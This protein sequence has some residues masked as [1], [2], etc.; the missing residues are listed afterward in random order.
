[1]CPSVSTDEQMPS[2]LDDPRWIVVTA[3][4]M[5][6][7]YPL[8]SVG[9]V[10]GSVSSLL[11]F[12][13]GL[14]AA[15]WALLGRQPARAKWARLGLGPSRLS[16]SRRAASIVG[17]G[18][19]IGGLAAIDPEGLGQT[20]DRGRI[21]LGHGQASLLFMSLVV[22]PAFFEEVFFRGALQN[23]LT[24]RFGAVIAIGLA[25]L[26][27]ASLHLESGVWAAAFAFVLGLCLASLTHYSGS[28]REA[29]LI[30]ALNNTAYFFSQL[31]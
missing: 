19:L 22:M 16:L 6:S 17:V 4:L 26:L 20:A 5:A 24:R 14:G 23:V 10:A 27:F 7:I 15:A 25:S 21:Q 31:A 3:L 1:M 9:G 30:H 8:R 18:V 2:L 28:I 29:M 13:F 12:Q 11:A